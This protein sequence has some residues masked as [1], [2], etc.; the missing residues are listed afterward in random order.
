MQIAPTVANTG[1]NKRG[2]TFD[3]IFSLPELRHPDLFILMDDE[4]T[5]VQDHNYILS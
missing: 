4:G 3:A 1:E 5:A 2:T